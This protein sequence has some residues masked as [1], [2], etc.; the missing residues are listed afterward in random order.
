M[1]AADVVIVSVAVH[2]PSVQIN[3]AADDAVAA[4]AGGA[5]QLGHQFGVR[6]CHRVLLSICFVSSIVGVGPVLG[7]LILL[8]PLL[9]FLATLSIIFSCF[10]LA[11]LSIILCWVLFLLVSSRLAS[12]QIEYRENECA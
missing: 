6:R 11:L 7:G 4:T 8:T 3:P 2:T 10:V 9:R 5:G 1:S 12:S